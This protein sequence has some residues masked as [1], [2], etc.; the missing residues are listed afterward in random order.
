MYHRL[1]TSKEK[2]K[3]KSSSLILTF[4]HMKQR[5]IPLLTMVNP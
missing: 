2:I 3:I 1:K 4:K 5:N